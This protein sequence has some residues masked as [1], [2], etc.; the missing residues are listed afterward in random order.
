M[1]DAAVANVNDAYTI[2]AFTVAVFPSDLSRTVVD[3]RTEE[4]SQQCRSSDQVDSR[5]SQSGA[6][7]HCIP[8]GDHSASTGAQSYTV[9]IPGC[10]QHDL[11]SR[12]ELQR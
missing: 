2:S 11:P 5:Q 12:G 7:Q 4:T 1:I 6:Y 9:P 10:S 3:R 8:E